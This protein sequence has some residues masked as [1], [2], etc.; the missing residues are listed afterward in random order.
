MQ[1]SP[2][3]INKVLQIRVKSQTIRHLHKARSQSFAYGIEN[4]SSELHKNGFVATS[5][6]IL[7]VAECKKIKDE[8]P[9]LFRGEFDTGVYPDEW[10][11]R[12]GISLDNVTREICNAWK[13]SSCIASIVLNEDIGQ[14]VSELMNWDS[15]RLAQDDVI[16]K[17]PLEDDNSNNGDHSTCSINKGI[18]TVG[19]HQDSAYIS[20]QFLPQENNSVTVWFA[21]DNI[22]EESGCLEYA[23]GSHLWRPILHQIEEEKCSNDSNLPSEGFHSLDENSYRNSISVAA[24][25]A[26]IEGNVEQLIQKVPVPMGHAIFH[27]QDV[28]HGSGPNLSKS[29]HRRALVAH[30]LKGDIEF[31]ENGKKS[32]APWGSTSYIYGRYKKHNSTHV[33]ESFFP[34][35]YA[36]CNSEFYRTEWIDSYTKRT[37]L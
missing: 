11:Y 8:I 18:N 15:V 3:W 30:Y 16:W 13:S 24:A 17:T 6:P 7:S 29:I 35:V 9:K 25:R 2:N 21:L 36:N 5:F 14:I 12:E 1:Q 34:V 32:S 28:W 22:Y 10:H 37:K 19:F 33:D 4:I 31:R 20:T 26:G 23:I 27:H